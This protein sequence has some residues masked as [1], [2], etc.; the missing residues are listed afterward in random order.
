MVTL[1]ELLKGKS[2]K[3]NYLCLHDCREA[4][5]ML[6]DPARSW[7][8]SAKDNSWPQQCNISSNVASL[9]PPCNK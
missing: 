2:K 4:I 5:G 8:A 3:N 9:L 7:E 6:K 1:N